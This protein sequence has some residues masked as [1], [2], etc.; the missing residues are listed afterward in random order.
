MLASPVQADELESNPLVEDAINRG[1]VLPNEH[2]LAKPTV[3][4][5]IGAK[6]AKGAAIGNCSGTLIAPD[7]VLTAAHC[8]KMEGMETMVVMAIPAGSRKPIQASSWK[9]HPHFKGKVNWGFFGIGAKLVVLND[10]A[11][12]KLSESAGAGTTVAALPAGNLSS[13]VNYKVN[14]VG[15]GKPDGTP[16]S[17][18]GTLRIGSSI[19]YL[20]TASDGAPQFL[21]MDSGAMTCQGDSGGPIYLDRGGVITV[22]GVVSHGDRACETRSVATSVSH[23]LDWI[24]DTRSQLN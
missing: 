13:G 21:R 17:K 8:L 20:A 16:E 12:V 11:L 15:F 3:A 22:V 1:Q 6:G 2:R 23:F 18:P 4:L 19:A 14:P 9:T 5:L 7:L 24:R 10:I